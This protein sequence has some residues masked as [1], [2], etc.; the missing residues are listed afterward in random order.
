M[1]E[2]LCANSSIGSLFLRVC[3]ASKWSHAAVWD[4]QRGVVTHTTLWGG[5]VKEMESNKFFDHYPRF[6]ITDMGLHD[7]PSAREWLAAQVDKPYDFTALFWF[8]LQLFFTRDW[9]EADKW[10]CSELTET[11]RSKFGTPR[12]RESLA[13]VSPRHMGMLL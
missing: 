3:M 11:V 2:V 12:F 13:H 9:Q 4:M 7:E 10:F 6:Q 8:P 1:Y 5:G